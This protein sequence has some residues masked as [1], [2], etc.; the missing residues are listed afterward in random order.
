MDCSPP[1][2]SVHGILQAKYWSRRSASHARASSTAKMTSSGK[3][4]VLPL[5]AA[6]APA[7]RALRWGTGDDA[8]LRSPPGLTI[9]FSNIHWILT[10]PRAP[11]PS[12]KD[13]NG[14]SPDPCLPVGW[15]VLNIFSFGCTCCAVCRVLEPGPQ[16]VKTLS[17][18]HWTFHPLHVLYLSLPLWAILPLLTEDGTWDFS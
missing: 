4:P 5:L 9:D 10:G 18:N 14:A 13:F 11:G 1:A 12:Q 15:G 16:A 6:R 3:W 17:P 8:K 2:S 7:P